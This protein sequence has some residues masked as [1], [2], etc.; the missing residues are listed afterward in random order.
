MHEAHSA[1][2]KLSTDFWGWERLQ[3]LSDF[4]LKCWGDG[5]YSGKI[6]RCQTS[7]A[8]CLKSMVNTFLMLYWCLCVLFLWTE[9]YVGQ[10]FRTSGSSLPDNAS[11]PLM[12]HW[13]CRRELNTTRAMDVTWVLGVLALFR[14]KT[15]WA[16]P[17]IFVDVCRKLVSSCFLES[18]R[19]SFCNSCKVSSMRSVNTQKAHPNLCRRAYSMFVWMWVCLKQLTTLH[20][21]G[22]ARMC[23][24][25]RAT[26]ECCQVLI[27]LV[28][29]SAVAAQSCS[30]MI[31]SLMVTDS[32]S[33]LFFAQLM[34]WWAIDCQF[35]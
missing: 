2:G 1:G 27:K 10:G 33:K 26:R 30:N 24:W 22:Q 32:F 21:S 34:D 14:M 23:Y 18:D 25:L 12:R 7:T 6:S 16:Q 3:D 29:L 35:N 4:F 17:K 5:S 15:L 20:C 19:R 11:L 8:R 13:M 28:L 9:R 31:K